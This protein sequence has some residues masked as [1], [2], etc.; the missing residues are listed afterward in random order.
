MTTFF[1]SQNRLE[2]ERREHRLE[3]QENEAAVDANNAEEPLPIPAAGVIVEADVDVVE[4][5]APP[6]DEDRTHPKRPRQPSQAVSPMVR[7]S[8]STRNTRFHRI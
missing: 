1:T 7:R 4:D 2:R 6:V 5:E 3:R 8:Q